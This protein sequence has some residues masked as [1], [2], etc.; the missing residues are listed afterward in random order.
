MMQYKNFVDHLNLGVIQEYL[1]QL[2]I[3]IQ[4]DN[5]K[6]AFYDVLKSYKIN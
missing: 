5:Y 4:E 3:E 1:S 2:L 6:D